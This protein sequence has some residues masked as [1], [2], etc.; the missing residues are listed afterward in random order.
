MRSTGIMAMPYT[1]LKEYLGITEGETR[2]YDLAQQLAIPE[3]WYLDRFRI[4]SVDLARY[5]VDES[6]SWQDATLL[7]GSSAL[8]PPWLDV[9]K[10]GKGYVCLD[11]DGDEIGRMPEG[12]AYFT[13]S[14]W[15]YR[16]LE[17]TEFS[18][19][20]PSLGK[21]LWGHVTDPLWA[22]EGDEDF[23]QQV[24][25]IASK[26][27]EE[28]EYASMIAFGGSFFE[29]GQFLYR[30]DEFLI[31][32]MIAPAEMELLLDQLLELHLAKLE[33]LLKQIDGKVDVIQFGDDYGT[34][35]SLMISQDTYRKFFYP[36]QKRLYQYVHDHSDL[37]VFLHSCGSVESIIPD[38]IDAG[39]D[40]L[41]PVQI[42]AHGMDPAFLK[43]EYG[44]DLVFWGGGIDTQHTL[45]NA[46]PQEVSDEVKRNCE[47]LMKDGG[48][49]FN[50]V[51][52][53]I[54]GVPPENIVAMYDAAISMG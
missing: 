33:V 8:F 12:V 20:I 27:R 2:V 1:R 29:M 11:S 39:V 46:S 36:R 9:R 10:E 25:Q 41:N 22:H 31:Q 16:G 23:Y 7:D 48:F 15:P 32:L 30:T 47:I 52:N 21:T 49:V 24:S 51:H 26:A 38:L 44:K 6:Q 3:Q 14:L 5:F 4:D 50:Q 35:S 28:T 53:I 19:L 37:K 13:Q 34:Q 54:E 17:K 45:A 43:K 18:D 42:G 40:I